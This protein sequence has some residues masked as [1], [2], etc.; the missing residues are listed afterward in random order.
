MESRPRVARIAD[1]P[2]IRECYL[3]SW[4]AATTATSPP[5]VLNAEAEKRLAFDW[6]RGISADTSTVFVA[7]DED[8]VV[9]VVQADESLPSPRDRPEITMLYVDPVAW[10]SGAATELLRAGSAVDR[11]ARAQRGTTARSRDPASGSPVL[12]TRGLG[13]GP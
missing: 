2:G 3:R 12:R 8:V 7:T 11:P 13:R 10:G 1:I 4:R 9:G 5:D 6:S